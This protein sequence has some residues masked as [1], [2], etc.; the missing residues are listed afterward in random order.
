MAVDPL[1]RVRRMSEAKRKQLTSDR[2]PTSRQRSVDYTTFYRLGSTTLE[3]WNWTS[4]PLSKIYQMRSD[5]MLG[6]GLQF[7]KVPLVRAPWYIECEDAQIAAFVDGALREIWHSFVFQYTN[8]YD[9]GYAPIIKNFGF[10][11]PSWTYVDPSD[12]RT[13]EKKVWDNGNINAVVWRPFTGIAPEHAMP[14]WADNGEF[15]GFLWSNPGVI[16]GTFAEQDSYRVPVDRALWAT[17]Q[18]EKVFGSLYGESMLNPAYRYWW[19]Y[20]FRMALAD[21]A[22]ERHVDP[23][24]VVYFPPDPVIDDETGEELN[25]RASAISVFEQARSGSTI[26]LPNSHIQDADGKMGEREWAWEQLNSNTDFAS[27]AQSL[28]YL[29]VMKL[30]SLAV[31][32]QALIEGSGGT[33]SRNVAA[34]MGDKLFESQ[35]VRMLE[36][37]EHCN[38]YLIPQ[39]VALNFPE[40]KG[41]VR[42]V[43]RGFASSDID[44]SRQLVQLLGQTNPAELNMVNIR[45]ILSQYQIPLFTET[46]VMQRVREAE[47]AQAER[48]IA[49]DLDI[50]GI[51]AAA[52]PGGDVR[53]SS[54]PLEKAASDTP[55]GGTPPGDR[56]MQMGP[57]YVSGVTDEWGRYVRPREV[58]TLADNDFRHTMQKFYPAMED[59]ETIEKSLEVQEIWES[60]FRTAYDDIADLVSS[61][62]LAD[63]PN[64]DAEKRL[65]ER[66]ESDFKKG[67]TA[68]SAVIAYL[69]LKSGRNTAISLG[70]A[71]SEL[72]EFDAAT[73][74]SSENLDQL[75]TKLAETTLEEI[76][77]FLKNTKAT[78][79]S[80]IS[81]DFREKFRN[82]PVWKSQRVAR[83]ESTTAFRM[84]QIL[85]ARELGS[86]RLRASDASNGTDFSTDQHCIDRHGKEYTIEE[87]ISETL[88]Q[89]HPNCTLHWSPIPNNVTY[90]S[91]DTENTSWWPSALRRALK[92]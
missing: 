88:G 71:P 92:G 34:Q 44:L 8:C 17:N 83:G 3:E 20:W 64:E 73:E 80:E 12:S 86:E 56:G 69:M 59:Q 85:T 52:G 18:K 36:I 62:G 23:A 30:R 29:D 1:E 25:V 91:E 61:I 58:I 57:G 21:R 67:A 90:A 40:F 42:K 65:M 19:S 74:W 2:G 51:P 48:E 77:T 7:I 53:D 72:G 55:P 37:D 46:E 35:Y 24:M 60:T 4:I 22:F 75:P 84:A 5:P 82:Y 50:E 13:P 9:F 81:A 89:S 15:D 45:E 16:A 87:A 26:A 31:P 66:L 47:A 27:L 14:K 49:K 43:T 79:P 39:L 76:K 6:F 54:A 33:S 38:R 28:D 32:E 70:Y 41:N 63:Q 10:S 78:T 11:K 68:A